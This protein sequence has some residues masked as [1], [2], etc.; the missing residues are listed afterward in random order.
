[1]STQDLWR[2]W[3]PTV[4]SF[5]EPRPTLSV[6]TTLTSSGP[7]DRDGKRRRCRRPIR[8]LPA[9]IC[10]IARERA[11]RL[12]QV[13]KEHQGDRHA[14]C[15]AAFDIKVRLPHSYAAFTLVRPL[16]WAKGRSDLR[17]CC[18][19]QLADVHRL[20]YWRH[21][22]RPESA[23]NRRFPGWWPQ[24]RTT[25]FIR[26]RRVHGLPPR[27]ED[28]IPCRFL[29]GYIPGTQHH[30]WKV[31][32]FLLRLHCQH[33]SRSWFL[34]HS[35]LAPGCT[36]KEY[37]IVPDISPRHALIHHSPWWWQL[38]TAPLPNL[39]AP[40]PCS[41]PCAAAREGVS[42]SHAY[43]GRG[44]TEIWRK[45]FLKNKIKKIFNKAFLS[46]YPAS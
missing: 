37:M 45:P 18:V 32:E 36:H 39:D 4:T 3:P 42:N 41:W 33:Q 24:A 22:L 9:D 44:F 20:S 46:V 43:R 17:H 16:L 25:G 7:S 21:S 12:P 19:H 35:W 28:R 14:Y 15:A 38:D 31:M 40:P 5:Q 34:T 23:S 13:A 29:H 30:A 11:N 1:M 6:V 26:R 27:Q 2:C 8:S 10:R